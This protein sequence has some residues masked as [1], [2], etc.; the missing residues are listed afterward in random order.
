MRLRNFCI[1]LLVA[2]SALAIPAG[3][4]LDD[5]LAWQRQGDSGAYVS[6]G[7]HDWRG[8]SKYRSRPGLHAGY[9]IAMLAGSAVRTPWPGRVVAITPW[10][11][12]EVGVTVR[13]ENGWEATFGHITSSVTLGQSVRR[14]DLIGRVVVDHVDVKMRDSGG[15]YVDFA[16]HKLPTTGL[17]AVA[18][19]PPPGYSPAEKK[20]AAEAYREYLALLE[21]LAEDEALVRR[22]LLPRKALSER[23]KKLEAI[24]PLAR[25]HAELNGKSVPRKPASPEVAPADARPVTDALL[26]LSK[27]AGGAANLPP[28]EGTLP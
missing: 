9:D 10:Y 26:G 28:G 5:L 19:A 13:L 2:L 14:G 7:F 11:G 22:G 21:R 18:T 25:L 4:N 12:A 16:A 27:P 15:G 3:A 1:A 23:H 8:I 20:A 6:S 17:M 24:R